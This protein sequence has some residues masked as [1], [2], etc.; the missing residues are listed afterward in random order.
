MSSIDEVL[1]SQLSLG[2]PTPGWNAPGDFLVDP[3]EGRIWGS[4][5]LH[6]GLM[7]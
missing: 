5:G 7:P 2:F 1:T 3:T 6:Q 4:E